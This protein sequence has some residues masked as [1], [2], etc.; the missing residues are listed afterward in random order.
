MSNKKKIVTL[1]GPSGVGK[2][3]ISRRVAAALGYTYLDTGAMYRAVAIA[4]NRAGV[5]V[6]DEKR[7]AVFLD[8][9]KIRLSPPATEDGEVGVELN[10]EDISDSIRT[11]EASMLASQFS[12]VPV[13]R[14]KLTKMQQEMGHQEE[15]VAEGRD[16]GTVVFP[17]A[18]YKFFLDGDPQVRAKRRVEQLQRQGINQDES[19]ILKLIIERD[20]ND[21]QRTIAPLKKAQEAHTVDTSAL[22]IDQVVSAILEVVA[23]SA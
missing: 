6:A 13:V 8:T 12:A 10:G 22:T 21:S 5:G 19:E 2:S 7:I 3:T 9:I 16:T 18:A 20:N 11:P 14:S 15:I 17:A 4:L 23:C 1:D